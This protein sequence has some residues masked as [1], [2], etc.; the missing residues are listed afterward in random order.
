MNNENQIE[1]SKRG[2]KSDWMRCM[3]RNKLEQN[4]FYVL[5]C[6][7]DTKRENNNNSSKPVEKKNTCHC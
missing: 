7:I 6:S 4:I 5:L 2:I 3:K 1:E